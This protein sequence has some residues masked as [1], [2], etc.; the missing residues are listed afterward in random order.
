M[1]TIARAPVAIMILSKP[2]VP[3]SGELSEIRLI[4]K[5]PVA[6]QIRPSANA[7]ACHHLRVFWMRSD[8]TP[9]E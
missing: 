8:H 3:V 9:M 4:R 1:R 7:P 2:D 6:S 5:V